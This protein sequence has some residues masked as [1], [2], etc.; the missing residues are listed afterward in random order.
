MRGVARWWVVEG[1]V[2]NDRYQANAGKIREELCNL[3]A[4]GG[5]V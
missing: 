2:G 5:G 1:A 3:P 4:G